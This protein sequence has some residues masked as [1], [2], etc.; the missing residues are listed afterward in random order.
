MDATA[1]ARARRLQ[2]VAACAMLGVWPGFL[3]LLPAAWHYHWLLGLGLAVFPGTFLVT[4]TAELMH[5]CWHNYLPGLP[6]RLFFNLLNWIM[7]YDPQAFGIAHGYHHSKL[8]TYEDIEFYPLGEIRHPAKRKAFLLVEYAFGLLLTFSLLMYVVR[9]D[10]RYRRRY[11]RWLRWLSVGWA[12]IVFGGCGAAAFL[13]FRVPIPTIL[14]SYVV[15]VALGAS[16][17]HHDQLIQHH[18]IIAEGAWDERNRLT[19]NLRWPGPVNK[20]FHFFS[21]GDTREHVLHHTL[22]KEY[23]RPVPGAFPMPEDA[24]YISVGEYVRLLWRHWKEPLPPV[25]AAEAPAA[26]RGAE[27]SE[28]AHQTPSPRRQS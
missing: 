20:L 6:N 19:R 18:G 2:S 17:T 9:T 5:E 25:T 7:G 1:I 3:I 24:H 10:P 8:H 11:Q 15:A 12:V 27:V 4:W 16:L 14:L 23:S 26:S 21:H 13:L 22:V 28:N